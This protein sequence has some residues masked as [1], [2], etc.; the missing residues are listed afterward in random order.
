MCVDVKASG[1]L[2]LINLSLVRQ[3][4]NIIQ[5]VQSL[6]ERLNSKILKSFSW[7]ACLSAA[8]SVL[9]MCGSYQR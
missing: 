3:C 6:K 8:W 4:M 9:G 7:P 5:S 1:L 2:I